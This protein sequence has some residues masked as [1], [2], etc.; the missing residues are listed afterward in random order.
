MTRHKTLIDPCVAVI[1]VIALHYIITSK[2]PSV[3]VRILSTLRGK[4]RKHERG[5]EDMV[6]K[7]RGTSDEEQKKKNRGGGK[8]RQGEREVE[9]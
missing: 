1:N 6:E 5:R 3:L 2:K 4:W 7:K 9:R 8:E